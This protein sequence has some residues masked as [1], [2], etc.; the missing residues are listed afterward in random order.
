MPS[1]LILKQNVHKRQV[2]TS[3]IPF[4]LQGIVTLKCKTKKY[5]LLMLIKV[6]FIV[7]FLL[8]LIRAA[9]AEYSIEYLPK[10]MQKNLLLTNAVVSSA[11]L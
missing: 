10:G 2:P 11:N 8:G 6:A 3:C 7:Y 4:N 9:T 1:L 5:A